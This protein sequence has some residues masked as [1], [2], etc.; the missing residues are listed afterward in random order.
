MPGL[1]TLN[2]LLPTADGRRFY[3]ALE[4]AIALS[5]LGRTVRLFLQGEAAALLREPIEHGGD[6]MRAAAG[7]PELAWMVE[8]ARAMGVTIAVCQSGMAL[9]GLAATDID[10]AF[11]PT[12]LISFL[13]DIGP[14]DSLLVY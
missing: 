5:A 2:F 8:E 6:A 4:T 7:Q 14:G 1:Q 13:A 12:G 10:A 3:A 11:R 9:V